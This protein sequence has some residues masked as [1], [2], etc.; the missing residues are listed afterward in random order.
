MDTTIYKRLLGVTV[1][2]TSFSVTAEKRI[3]NNG[4]HI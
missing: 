4:K 1:F 2:K 3:I